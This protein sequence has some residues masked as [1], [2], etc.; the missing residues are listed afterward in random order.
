NQNLPTAYTG[1]TNQQ[2]GPGGARPQGGDGRGSN[3]NEELV[4]YLEANT[5]G[6]EYLLAVP[7]S[8]Q[9]SNLVLATGRPVLFMGGFSGQD[10]VVTAEDLAAMVA[11]GE[12]R[13]VMYGGDRGGKQT[14]T[15]WLEASCTVAPEFNQSTAATQQGPDG[16]GPNRATT[17]YLCE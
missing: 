2:M 4:N 10:E 13:Y 15:N 12:L 14:I 17:L 5:Q 8:Q 11:N 7:S 1:S 9:G 16:G 3:V 6:M